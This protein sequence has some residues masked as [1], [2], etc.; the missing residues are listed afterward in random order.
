MLK[1]L[2]KFKKLD[3]VLRTVT[4]RTPLSVELWQVRLCFHLS[5]DDE[6]LGLAVFRDATA[7]LGSDTEAAL[8]LWKIMLQYYQT[9]D[10]HKVEQ[11]FQEGIMQGCA[12]S[13]PLKPLY[14][15]WLVSAK[16]ELSVEL[17]PQHKIRHELRYF[18]IWEFKIVMHKQVFEVQTFYKFLC[19]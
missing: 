17:K 10:M 18:K 3:G 19:V 14:I 9:K 1:S 7:R 8:P 5:R 13:L 16:G 11:M 4:E 12:I 6:R 2:G 15:E